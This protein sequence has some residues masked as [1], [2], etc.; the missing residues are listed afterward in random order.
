MIEMY[1]R[2]GMLQRAIDLKD[3]GLLLSSLFFFW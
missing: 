3:V 2:G 1:I